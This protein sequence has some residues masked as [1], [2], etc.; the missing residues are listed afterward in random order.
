MIHK[1]DTALAAAIGFTR[2]SLNKWRANHPDYPRELDDEAWR[3]FIEK[4]GLG[5]RGRKAN[6]SREELTN[7]KLSSEIR[8]NEI[9]IA[10]EE[11]KL[12]PADEIE[13]F[14]LFAA[15]KTKSA[16]YQMVAETSPK[17]AGLDAGEIRGIMRA[18]ADTVCMSLQTTV[19]DWQAEQDEAR[20][21][22]QDAVGV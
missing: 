6:K 11:R 9:K 4:N 19:E 5:N 3:A 22:A 20:R 13:S 18:A 16:L 7:E 8:L 17:C 14:L 2:P 21:A 15:S 12:V 1:T 10:K